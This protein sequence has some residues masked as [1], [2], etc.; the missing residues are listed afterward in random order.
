M[1]S[2]DNDKNDTYIQ[3]GYDG[4]SINGI[5]SNKFSFKN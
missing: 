3:L 1:W 4:L 5:G 2:L